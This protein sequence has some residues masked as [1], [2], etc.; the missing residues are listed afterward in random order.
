MT[1]ERLGLARSGS[2]TECP[3]SSH[4]SV[5]SSGRSSAPGSRRTRYVPTPGEPA[6]NTERMASYRPTVESLEIHG[7]SIFLVFMGSPP[8]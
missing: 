8:P 6:Q 1:W 2:G 4:W 7:G 3:S 5:D